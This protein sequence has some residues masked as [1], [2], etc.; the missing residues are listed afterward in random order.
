L[1]HLNRTTAQGNLCLLTVRDSSAEGAEWL[2]CR[3][4][5]TMRL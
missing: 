2:R 5:R 3:V 4:W 1:P